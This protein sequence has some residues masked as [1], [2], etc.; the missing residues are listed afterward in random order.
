[1]K[2]IIQ[3]TKDKPREKLSLRGAASLSDKELMA[4][5]LG[6]GI[7]GRNVMRI[8]EELVNKIDAAAEIDPKALSKIPGIGLA[9]ATII[10]AAMEFSRRRLHSQNIKIR[11]PKDVVLLLGHLIDR[12]QEHLVSISLN[13]AHEVIKSRIV[14]IGTANSAV[15]HP[16]EIFS[17]SIKDGSCAIVLAHN[18]PSGNLEP[19]DEDRKVTSRVAEAGNILGIK[20][21]D[22]VIFGRSGF[23]SFR[24]NGFFQQ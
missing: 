15:A 14:S 8:A 5:L 2:N 19:S 9:K 21:L 4:I 3:H 7:R 6:S 10:S 12:Q 24:E 23:Y 1:M 13:G 17:G 11:E 16:R 22:H 18:H 20:L